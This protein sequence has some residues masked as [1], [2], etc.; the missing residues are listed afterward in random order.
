MK[1]AFLGDIGLIGEYSLSNGAYE[2]IINIGNFLKDFD[3]VVANLET[4]LTKVNHSKKC[5]SMHLKSN[6][7]NTKILNLLNI[8]AVTLANNHIFDYGTKG[9]DETIKHLDINGIDYFGVNNKS[10]HLDY[11]GNKIHFSGYCCYSTNGSQYLNNKIGIHPL[12]FS[13][14]NEQLKI[15]KEKKYLSVLSLHWGDEHTNF[16]NPDQINFVSKISENANFLIH[17][18]H[19]HNIQGVQKIKNNLVAYSLGNF[20]FDDCISPFVKNFVVKKNDENRKSFILSV[21]I[22]DNKITKY[23]TI[24]IYD[25]KDMGIITKNI[26]N[27]LNYISNNIY[28]YKQKKYMQLRYN[29][30]QTNRRE[31]FSK[32]DLRWFLSKLNYY[33]IG[34]KVI[35]IL[36]KI[37]YYFAIKKNIK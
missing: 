32:R 7:V 37:R 22:L 2:R 24:G 18:H 29:Q 10:I 3:Y 14:I 25:D 8:N 1:I 12:K 31:K 27:E 30:I 13:K 34:S 33:S 23:D 9:L 21:E 20:C 15:D 19:T 35:L 5:K 16:P 11:D 28:N 36:N 4:P 17:G 26:N 6:P